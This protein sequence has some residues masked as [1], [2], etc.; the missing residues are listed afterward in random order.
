M[1]KQKVDFDE[2]LLI[3]VEGMARQGATENDIA[4]ALGITTR[5]LYTYRQTCPK[6]AEAMKRGKAVTDFTVESA[7]Y[8]RA[9]GC[10]ETVIQRKV[11]P[12]GSEIVTETVKHIAPDTAACARWLALRCPDRWR[13]LPI[14]AGNNNEETTA[15]IQEYLRALTGNGVGNE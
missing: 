12:D 15:M 3:M 1:S 7:L 11:L 9:V 10:T 6:L 8:R 5:T 14:E 13:E 2:D 4:K